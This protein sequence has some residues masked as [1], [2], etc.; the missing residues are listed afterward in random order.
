LQQDRGPQS[1]KLKTNHY[2]Q[3]PISRAEFLIQTILE[4]NFII[5]TMKIRA[6][7]KHWQ[8]LELRTINFCIKFAKKE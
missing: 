2:L 4:N 7:S 8:S 3:A 5:N 6:N 1:T